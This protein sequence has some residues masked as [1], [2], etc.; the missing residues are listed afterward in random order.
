[1]Y[2]VDNQTVHVGI[3]VT[4]RI[5][6]SAV[7]H[8]L[9]QVGR[10][11]D[12]DISDNMRPVIADRALRVFARR[13]TLGISAQREDIATEIRRDVST[14]LAGLF[15]V[16]VADLQLSTI[17]YSDAFTASVENA[18]RAKNEA[19]AAENQVARIHYEGEQRKVQAEA[20]A[21]ARVTQAQAEKQAAILRAE[22]EAQALTLKGDA[23]AHVIAARATALGDNPALVSY[24]EAERWNGQ[25]PATVLG[26]QMGT[27]PVFDVA[28]AARQ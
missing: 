20:D 24:T 23:E 27:L 12:V 14:A 28:R 3:A 4:Y 21:V 11:G 17:R 25:L 19:A 13:N 5:P 8:L 6:A 15:G 16:E 2:T 22:G 1:V 9:Y 7:L 18:M 10:P 26:G